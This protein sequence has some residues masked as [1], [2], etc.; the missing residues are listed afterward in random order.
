MG[1]S[2]QQRFMQ[3]A[4]DEASKGL[5]RTCPNPAVGCVVVKN[6]EIVATGYHAEP[7][8]VTTLK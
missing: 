5:G 2:E 3:R 7:W 4:I 6:G 1:M 8:A